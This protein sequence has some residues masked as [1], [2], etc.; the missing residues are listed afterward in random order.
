MLGNMADLDVDGMN[1]TFGMWLVLRA[2]FILAY[3]NIESVG[4]SLFRTGVWIV[5]IYQLLSVIVR[6]GNVL[7]FR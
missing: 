5:S 6:A 7:A 3:V 1:R 4:L 2:V